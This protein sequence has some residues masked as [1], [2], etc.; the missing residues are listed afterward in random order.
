MVSIKMHNLWRSNESLRKILMLLGWV[1]RSTF[2]FVL[3]YPTS[4][5]TVVPMYAVMHLSHNF[6]NTGTPDTFSTSS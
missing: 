3:S 5:M 1:T 6:V 2:A 4:K